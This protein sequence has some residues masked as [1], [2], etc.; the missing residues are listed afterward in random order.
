MAG[1]TDAG[2]FDAF[3]PPIV[4]TWTSA[5]PTSTNVVGTSAGLDTIAL[6]INCAAG[7]S[8]GVISFYVF[9]GVAYIPIKCPSVSNYLT[10][11]SYTLSGGATAGFTVPV[12]GYPAFQFVLTSAITGTG[13]VYVTTIASSAPDVS[14]VAAGID[15]SS[16]SP[17]VGS[18]SINTGQASI[19]TSASLLVAARVGVGGNGSGVA[20]TGRQSVN[21]TNL[22]SATIYV[23]PT[24]GVTTGTGHA[25]PTTGS[26]VFNTAAALY[27]ISGSASQTVTY[28]ETF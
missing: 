12:A 3:A 16:T 11:S 22:G 15:P 5:T 21:V 26:Q 10:Y 1:L 25:I 28:L 23:G 8:G 17:P 6:T 14:V 7:I 24:I 20:G 27:A 18:G 9:D 19:G 13:N 4:T 2:N